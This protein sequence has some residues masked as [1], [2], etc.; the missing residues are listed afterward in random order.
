[1]FPG[2][3][4]SLLSTI[5]DILAAIGLTETGDIIKELMKLD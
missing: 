4:Y 1:M 2:P 5:V 3:V